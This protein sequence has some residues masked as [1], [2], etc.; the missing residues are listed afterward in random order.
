MSRIDAGKVEAT[1]RRMI[2]DVR[3]IEESRALGHAA[4][5]K[6]DDL[7]QGRMAAGWTMLV[8]LLTGGKEVAVHHE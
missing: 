7:L 1:L 5:E 6:L 3:A 8:V 4:D 2:L